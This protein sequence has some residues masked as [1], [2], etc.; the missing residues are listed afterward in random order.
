MLDVELGW[1]KS[2]NNIYR[3]NLKAPILYMQCIIMHAFVSSV[4]EAGLVEP[5]ISII[6]T[7]IN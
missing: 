7:F 3:T 5:G 1:E 4:V 2:R 6:Y